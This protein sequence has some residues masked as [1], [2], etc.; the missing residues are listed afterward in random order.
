MEIKY[1][2]SSQDGTEGSEGG[3]DIY[4]SN[5]VEEVL[6]IEAYGVNDNAVFSRAWCSYWGLA[7]VTGDV[8]TTCIACCVR[9][10]YAASVKVVILTCE[11]LNQENEVEDVDRTI[12][13]V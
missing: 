1:W 13:E 8:D 7:A 4:Y 12:L 11:R 3:S 2:G 6:V 5:E 9:E 10:A